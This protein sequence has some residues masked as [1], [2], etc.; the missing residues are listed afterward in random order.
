MSSR[1]VRVLEDGQ[2]NIY[3]PYFVTMSDFSSSIDCIEDLETEFGI[4]SPELVKL[5]QWENIDRNN[6]DKLIERFKKHMAYFLSLPNDSSV[7]IWG[8]HICKWIAAW[9]GMSLYEDPTLAQ[10][11][12]NKEM[13]NIKNLKKF[14]TDWWL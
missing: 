11:I 3:T 1:I 6:V 14:I 7:K 12:A 8:Q 13:E 4:V 9:F 10:S 2:T 5:F